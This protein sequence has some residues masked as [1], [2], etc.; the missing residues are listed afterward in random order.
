VR[1]HV[2]PVELR[3][4]FGLERLRFLASEDGLAHRQAVAGSS[5]SL[6]AVQS[7]PHAWQR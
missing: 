1:R 2:Q 5:R 7:R 3:A 6:R 4:D